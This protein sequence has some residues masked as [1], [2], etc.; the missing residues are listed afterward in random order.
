[1]SDKFVE[2]GQLYGGLGMTGVAAV[3]EVLV[4]YFIIRGS[5]PIQAGI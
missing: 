4:I 3:T 2:L 5:C 1:M